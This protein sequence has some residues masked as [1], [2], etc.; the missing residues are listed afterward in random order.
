[1]MPVMRTTVTLDPDV[2]AKLRDTMRERGVSFKVALNDA[3]R[4]GLQGELKPSRPFK[5]M[6][7]PMGAR[8]N[9]DK[10]LTIAAE[11]EDD[12][13]IRKLELGK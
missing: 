11:L 5:V 8:F 6:S 10:A 9:I 2:E 1:M 13:I 7:S 12:E 3:V 4:S